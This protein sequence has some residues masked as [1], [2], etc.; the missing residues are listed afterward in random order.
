[1]LDPDAA[2]ALD[3]DAYIDH[4]YRARPVSSPISSWK[5]QLL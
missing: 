4:R 5:S 2:K 3:L 1:M